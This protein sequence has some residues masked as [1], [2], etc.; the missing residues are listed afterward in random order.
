LSILGPVRSPGN[1]IESIKSLEFKN[2]SWNG[3]RY[4]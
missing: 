4:F 1:K 3:A 2:S